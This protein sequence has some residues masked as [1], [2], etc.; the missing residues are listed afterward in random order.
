[1]KKTTLYVLGAGASIGANRYPRDIYFQ[2]HSMPS[3]PNFF[4]DLFLIEKPS[5]PELDFMNSLD[6]TY[7]GLNKII[8]QAWK[9]PPDRQF[10]DKNVWKGVNIEDVFTFFDVGEKIYGKGSPYNK[11]FKKSKEDL[12]HFIFLM[13]TMRSVGQRC[14]FLNKIFLKNLG[15]QDSIISFNWD[16]LA[17]TTLEYLQKPH[18]KNYLS[19]FKSNKLDEAKLSKKG[20]LLKLHGSIN[21][22]YCT[23][24]HCKKFNKVQIIKGRG[25]KL[26]TLS[27]GELDNCKYC[28]SKM[29]VNI[30]PPTSNKIGIHK[31]SFI[32]KQWLICREKFRYTSKLVFI[33]YSFPSTDFYSEWLFRQINF[34]MIDKDQFVKMEIDVVNPEMLDHKSLTYQRYYNIFR[35]HKINIFKDL[36]SYCAHIGKVI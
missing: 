5:K 14:H 33:G 30:I 27:L 11:A 7:T 18:Y 13:I 15:D 16:T 24:K 3:G 21:W 20:L 32:H 6:M 19:L 2:D 4:Y 1:M 25:D 10:W 35:G 8:V 17:E 29:K 28:G 12:M 23:N 36:K 26:I 31:D 22:M 9:L 34:L